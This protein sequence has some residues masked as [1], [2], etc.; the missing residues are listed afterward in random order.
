LF[1]SNRQKGT[2]KLAQISRYAVALEICLFSH[3]NLLFKIG[4]Q[5]KYFNINL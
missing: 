2:E 1:L 4:K 5:Q 3:Q